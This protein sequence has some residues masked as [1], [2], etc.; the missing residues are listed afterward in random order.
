ML[1]PRIILAIARKDA[2]DI[3]HNKSTLVGLLMPVFIAVLFVIMKA[4][5]SGQSTKLLIYD[6][7]Q[8]GM[9]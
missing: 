3:L 9:A 2:V 4:I 7:G 6:P 8:A 1:H 5:F